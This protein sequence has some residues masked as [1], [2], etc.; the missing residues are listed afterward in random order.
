[1]LDSIPKIDIVD[2]MRLLGVSI[3]NSLTFHT[4][5]REIVQK[6]SSMLQI[7]K[8]FKHLI[9]MHATERLYMAYFLPHLTY[10]SVIWVHCGK[11]NADKLERLDESILRFVFNDFNIHMINY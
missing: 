4:H 9:P 11:R 8:Q 5:V 2:K 7:L 3:D 10:C 1:M 6:D